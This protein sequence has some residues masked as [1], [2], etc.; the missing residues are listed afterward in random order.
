MVAL[1]TQEFYCLGKDIA[2]LAVLSCVGCQRPT[3][4]SVASR[5]CSL[6]CVPKISTRDETSGVVAVVSGT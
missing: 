1:D 3:Q 4:V 2:S 5:S 6:V